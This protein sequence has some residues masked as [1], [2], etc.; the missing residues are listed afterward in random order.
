M[1]DD[2]AEY[3]AFLSLTGD[4]FDAPGMPVETAREVGNFREAILKIARDLWMDSNPDRQR[5]PSGF[6]DAFDLRLIDVASG[7]AR[8][9][10]K[11]HRSSQRVSDDDWDDWSPYYVQA[12]DKLTESLQ[13]VAQTRQ[14]PINLSSGAMRAIRRVGSSL[15]DSESIILGD[16]KHESRRAVIDHAVREILEEIEELAPAPEIAQIEGVIVE[17][18]GST[19]SFRVKTNSGISTCR[20]DQERQDLAELAKEYLATDGVT[21]P[22][23]IVQGETTDATQKNIQLFSITSISAVRSI[24]EKALIASLDVISTLQSGWLGPGS[25]APDGDVVEKA[26]RL[27]PRIASLGMTISMVPNADGAIVLEWKRGHVEMSAA[28]EAHNGLFLCSDNTATDD[29]L[30]SQTE[31]DE[32]LLLRFL[33]AGSMK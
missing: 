15:Q 11:L 27:L 9:R 6:Y 20:L 10:M 7:S 29:L 5:L 17:Y 33:E 31:Y 26:R 32:A 8:P 12:R 1:Y 22:D 19:M 14:A 16:P 13:R 24:K 28:I 3:F 21:A 30:E 18:D 23:V 2:E 25:K 4:R